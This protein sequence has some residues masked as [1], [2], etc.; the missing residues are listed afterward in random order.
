MLI[1]TNA[2]PIGRK[3][4]LPLITNTMMKRMPLIEKNIA[5][6]LYDFTLLDVLLSTMKVCLPHWALIRVYSTFP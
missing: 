6:V 3:A 1:I 4:I 2:I 5:A